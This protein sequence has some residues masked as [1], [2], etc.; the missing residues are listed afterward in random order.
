MNW[1][2]SHLWDFTYDGYSITLPSEDD[3]WRDVVDAS[4]LRI[5]KIL[6][7]EKDKIEYTY[8]YGDD[9]K[10]KITL[11]KILEVDKKQIYPVCIKGKRACP[12][13]DCGG[14][15]G[16]VN[17][18]E[19][20]NNINGQYILPVLASKLPLE[21]DASKYEILSLSQEEKLFKI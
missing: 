13:D 15:W 3:D 18:L 2:N 6:A 1:T 10:H 11:E 7:K 4:D 17:L 12:P 19:I 16:Y 14:P 21:I 9:W 20:I 5:S 8:D